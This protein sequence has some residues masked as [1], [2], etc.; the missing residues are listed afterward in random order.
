[1]A[2]TYVEEDIWTR[3]RIEPQMLPLGKINMV[4]SHEFARLNHK[5]LK[6]EKAEATLY[7]QVS[8]SKENRE[9][10]IY[11][12]KYPE[13]GRSIQMKIQSAFP[14]KILSWKEVLNYDD[15]QKTQTTIAT[16]THT[17]MRAYWQDNAVKNETLRDSLGLRYGIK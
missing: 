5:G 13:L 6:P 14:F 4:P 10:Y 8:D 16:L 3:A 1:M 12:L 9:I 2:A 11:T 17:E 7:L 15:P